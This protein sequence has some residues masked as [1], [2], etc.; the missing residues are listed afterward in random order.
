MNVGSLPLEP[1][2][3]GIF[4]PVASETMSLFLREAGYFNLFPSDEQNNP[5]CCHYFSSIAG[6]AGDLLW[7]GYLFISFISFFSTD[8]L[9]FSY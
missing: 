5:N 7:R 8:C 1:W 2:G 3:P 4:L 6:E 9:S